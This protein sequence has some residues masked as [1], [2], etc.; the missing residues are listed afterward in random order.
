MLKLWRYYFLFRI[1]WSKTSV[2]KLKWRIRYLTV[3]DFSYIRAR[4]LTRVSLSTY[5]ECGLDF[6]S[7]IR[8]INRLS[9][10]KDNRLSWDYGIL[11][12]VKLN[13]WLLGVGYDSTYV[14]LEEVLR[15]LTID[16]IQWLSNLKGRSIEEKIIEEIES[17]VSV[18][19]ELS[20]ISSTRYYT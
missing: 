10:N 14:S 20:D 9:S 19:E 2:D 5:T 16:G 17:V 8:R 13:E 15:V 11:T 3:A 12:P 18:F 4:D 6:I 7:G 1:S